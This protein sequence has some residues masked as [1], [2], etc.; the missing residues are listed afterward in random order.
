[1]DGDFKTRYVYIYST[2]F[3]VNQWLKLHMSCGLAET[4][5]STTSTNRVVQQKL[6]YSTNRVVQKKLEYLILNRES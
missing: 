5:R 6:E 3:L 4:P 2:E 1:M